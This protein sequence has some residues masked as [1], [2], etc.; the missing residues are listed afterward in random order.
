[1]DVLII[2]TVFPSNRL[3]PHGLDAK[4]IAFL[5]TRGAE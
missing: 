5:T 1:M 3:S 2:A 4:S